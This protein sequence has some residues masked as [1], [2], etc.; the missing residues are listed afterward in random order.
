MPKPATEPTPQPLTDPTAPPM[1]DPPDAPSRDP[2]TPPASDPDPKPM[3]DPG[4]PT[5]YR[6]PPPSPTKDR[7]PPE[8]APNRTGDGEWAARR[9]PAQQGVRRVYYSASPTLC[10]S[11]DLSSSK[12]IA[13][14]GHLSRS[15]TRPELRSG[16]AAK[17]SASESRCLSVLSDRFDMDE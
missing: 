16:E 10:R 11:E 8:E 17:K 2:V 7:A 1:R 12:S 6:D 14:G 15:K 4:Q 5:P 9:R 13:R 3:H